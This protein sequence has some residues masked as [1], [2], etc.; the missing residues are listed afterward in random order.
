MGKIKLFAKKHKRK[1]MALLMSAM[2]I[3]SSSVSA[4]ATDGS[5]ESSINSMELALESFVDALTGIQDNIIA[6]IVAAI[7][8]GL[9]VFGVTVAITKGIGFVKKL[10]G[11]AT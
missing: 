6:F 3:I 4:F 8:T 5:T 7:P 11:K 2:M 10:L 1:V 9:A